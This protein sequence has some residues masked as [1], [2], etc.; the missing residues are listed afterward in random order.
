MNINVSMNKPLEVHPHFRYAVH[1]TIVHHWST[2]RDWVCSVRSTGRI[3][4][5]FNFNPM[6]S[7]SGSIYKCAPRI[8]YSML[9]C[10]SMLSGSALIYRCAP[11]IE[12]RILFRRFFDL[13]LRLISVLWRGYT[14]AGSWRC[15]IVIVVPEASAKV[16]SSC[17]EARWTH[18]VAT[19]SSRCGRACNPPHANFCPFWVCIFATAVTSALSCSDACTDGRSI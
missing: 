1:R 7:G 6:L 17:F 15:Y 5:V 4:K 18:Q 14:A 8:E 9:S 11:R 3:F 2:G 16:S 19:S 12:H 10:G 13:S